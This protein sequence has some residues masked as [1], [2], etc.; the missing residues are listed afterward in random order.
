MCVVNHVSNINKTQ[1]VACSNRSTPSDFIHD[2][3]YL[4]KGLKIKQRLREHNNSPSL[5]LAKR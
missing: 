3:D 1:V 2:L 4:E 5:G